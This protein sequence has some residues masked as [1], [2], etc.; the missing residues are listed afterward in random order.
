MVVVFY[1]DVSAP[2]ALA[3]LAHVQVLPIQH[4]DL[5]PSERLVLATPAKV[6]QLAE[7]DEVLRIYLASES[8]IAGLPVRS[9][10]GA[11][12][13]NSAEGLVMES[14]VASAGPG[15]RQ[16]SG[17]TVQ[18]SWNLTSG[19]G[20]PLAP[21]IR[22][23]IE[24]A[25]SEWTRH[26]DIQISYTNERRKAKSIDFLFGSE[27]HG[28][29]FPFDSKGGLLAHA[30]YPAGTNPEPI[31][32]DVHFDA[33]ETWSEAGDPE[34]FSAALHEVGHSLGLGHSDTP[35][36]VM[37]PYY[38]D[39]QKLADDDVAALLRLY[40]AAKVAYDNLAIQVASL[41]SATDANSISMSGVVTGGKDSV[42]LSWRVNGITGIVENA[43][44]WQIASVPLAIGHNNITLTAVD[45]DGLTAEITRVVLRTQP[46]PAAP[47]PVPMPSPQ[48]PSVPTTPSSTPPTDS[49]SS[50]TEAGEDVVAPQ[51]AITQPSTGVYSVSSAQIRIAGTARD[52]GGLASINWQTAGQSGTAEG[53]ASWA[54]TLP[55]LPGQ[56][57]VTV[58]ARDKA[59]NV[60]SR[61][62]VVNRR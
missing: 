9:C 39:L 13:D 60:S 3:V 2:D 20:E 32:G 57:R 49:T 54:F 56:N 40:S 38:S 62:V 24:R 29:P 11:T 59:G 61:S 19:S 36:S 21:W 37:Y 48:A 1:S 10:P 42:T 41:P 35:G 47:A 18:L 43:R 5:L 28:D 12:T 52:S 58:Q 14:L 15:W 33:D 53:T 6:T 7:W 25:L 55:L 17:T 50:R 46:E 22:T 26:A 8:L 4:P 44:S 45:H 51:L 23:Q 30:F 34:L 27:Y 16:A 31:A